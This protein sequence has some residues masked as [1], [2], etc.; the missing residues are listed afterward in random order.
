MKAIGAPNGLSALGF[1]SDD[2]DALSDK[3][4][5]Q[6]RV[7]ENAARLITRKEMRRMYA[8]ALSYW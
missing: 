7:I 4:W 3:G 1:S 5:K 2:L 8:G 6:R